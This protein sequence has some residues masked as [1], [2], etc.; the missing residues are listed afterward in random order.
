MPIGVPWVDG[1]GGGS[2]Y[3]PMC[4]GSRCLLDGDLFGDPIGKG[5]ACV[6]PHISDNV[7]ASQ[8]CLLFANCFDKQLYWLGQIKSPEYRWWILIDKKMFV[9]K[10]SAVK[11]DYTYLQV[12]YLE[13]FYIHKCYY[14]KFLWILSLLSL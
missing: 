7:F 6:V 4:A 2:T 9:K 14:W 13:I 11:T 12:L 8:H 10:D 3:P 1:L 5:W